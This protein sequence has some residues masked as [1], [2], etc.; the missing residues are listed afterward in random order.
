MLKRPM[1]PISRIIL[2]LLIFL[3]FSSVL[4]AIHLGFS[5]NKWGEIEFSFIRFLCALFGGTIVTAVTTLSLHLFGELIDS[6]KNTAESMRELTELT[7]KLAENTAGQ[8]QRDS[9][10]TPATTK[11]DKSH[12]SSNSAPASERSEWI[13]CKKC[14]QSQRNNRTVCF[15]CGEK[16]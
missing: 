4:L 7:R 9:A 13:M 5:E 6:A 15:N 11:L 2:T 3:Y 1:K 14:G 10:Q 12:T 8:E 16:L